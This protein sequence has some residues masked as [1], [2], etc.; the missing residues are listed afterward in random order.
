MIAAGTTREASVVAVVLIPSL[1]Q[2]LRAR[3]GDKS[4]EE[5]MAL[6]FTDRALRKMR[7]PHRPIRG[8]GWKYTAFIAIWVA[9][10]CVLTFYR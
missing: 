5:A 7:E 9:L 8:A 6:E 3:R 2:Q 4:S 1:L 10:L